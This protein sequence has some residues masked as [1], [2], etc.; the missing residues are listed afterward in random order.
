[1]ATTTIVPASSVPTRIRPV[2]VEVKQTWNGDWSA[3]PELVFES[4]SCSTASADL[5]QATFS[6]RYGTVKYPWEQYYSNRMARSP[7]WW[8][9]RVRFAGSNGS[10][11]TAWV[12]QITG[13][14][15]KPFGPQNGAAGIQG[16]TAHGPLQ[17]LRKI[18]V[19]RSYWLNNG[20]Q[21]C[22]WVPD[23]NV[24]DRHGM[25]VGNRSEYQAYITNGSYVYGSNK[26]WTF[27]QYLEYILD[28]FVN[29]SDSGP[30]FTLGGQASILNQFTHPIRL[31]NTPTVAEILKQLIP[32]RFGLDYVVRPSGEG[33]SIHVFSLSPTST[34]FGE[35]T[36][37]AN[38]GRVQVA[39]TNSPDYE[40]TLEQTT[41]HAYGTLRVI[42]ERIVACCTLRG[43]EDTLERG[44][45]NTYETEYKD[46]GPFKRGDPTVADEY[47][48]SVLFR[49]VYQ[50]WVAAD[51]AYEG[52]VPFFNANGEY[53]RGENAEYQSVERETLSWLPL[54]VAADYSGSVS[55]ESDGEATYR[56]V[57]AWVKRTIPDPDDEENDM[58][59][60]TPVDRCDPAMGVSGLRNAL[61]VHINANPNHLLAKDRFDAQ[62]YATMV[63]PVYEFAELVCTVAYRTDQRIG[64]EKSATDDPAYGVLV[65]E[66]PDAEAWVLC[67]NTVVDADE[68]GELVTNG[69]RG[70]VL[71]SDVELLQACMAGAIARYQGTRA[72]AKVQ[73]RGLWAWNSLLGQILT[74]VQ[75]GAGVN[76]L[77]APITT[78]HWTGGQN[79]QTIVATG[80]AQ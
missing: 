40:V 56:H 60:W 7:L 22:G 67:A 1:M 17:I 15:R 57:A 65:I 42:G 9:V 46:G 16:Y 35:T 23:V 53:Q 69:P 14:V 58:D 20:L 30:Q 54:E 64:L 4:A 21:C 38:P 18:H 48:R 19:D 5:D 55:P 76:Q 6:Y 50:R 29:S 28:A 33:F 27:R 24:R 49:D 63:E 70:N 80:Y 12:G 77:G 78:I 25:V 68:D 41:E 13:E 45:T 75:E 74:A 31:G 2:V 36:I 51:A 8:W 26:V 3:A 11:T 66:V 79:P 44:W 71:R 10:L 34:S 52:A 43:D 32:A 59:V 37:Q 61:G 62:T 73:R 47:R 39:A 72:R